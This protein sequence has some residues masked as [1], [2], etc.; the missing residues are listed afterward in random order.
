[1]T[2]A[3]LHSGQDLVNPHGPQFLVKFLNHREITKRQWQ[4]IYP[5]RHMV[6]KTDA[7]DLPRLRRQSE[8]L[9]GQNAVGKQ[10]LPKQDVVR[11]VDGVGNDFERVARN[12]FVVV[13]EENHPGVRGRDVF[14][15]EIEIGVVAA[16]GKRL[17]S[18]KQVALPY[19][20]FV[21]EVVGNDEVEV[22]FVR[23]RKQTG[24]ASGEE[25]GTCARSGNDS[26]TYVHFPIGHLS[27]VRRV[28]K[29]TKQPH[30]VQR[31][32]L[33]RCGQVWHISSRFCRVDSST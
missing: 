24:A 7:G 31:L 12:Q 11:V 9:A 13:V 2:G 4:P 8:A 32:K 16:P 22:V 27:V 19:R 6:A 17:H 20:I 23:L 28:F 1:M 26:K 21:G 5:V 33:E 25:V 3:G 10:H 29:L 30:L 18:Q 14:G 15:S